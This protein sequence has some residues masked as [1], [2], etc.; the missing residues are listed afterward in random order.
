MREK[1][2][3]FISRHRWVPPVLT[4]AALVFLR[5]LTFEIDDMLL[6]LF[7][8]PYTIIWVLGGL[9]FLLSLLMG[10]AA[11][12]RLMNAAVVRMNEQCDPYA[13]LEE[14]NKQLLYVKSRTDR[15]MLAIN[16]A[17]ALVEMGQQTRAMEE[18]EAINTDDPVLTVQWRYV[19][20]HNL[21]LTALSCGQMEKAQVYYQKCL[22][23]FDSAK[24]KMRDK[25]QE[26]KTTLTAI[27]HLYHDEYEQAYAMLA[28]QN[29]ETLLTRVHRA[30]ALGRIALVQ[31]NIPVARV[32]LEFVA[33]NGGR[34]YLPAAANGLLADL[35]QAQAE[36]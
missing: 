7:G 8:G 36:Q 15:S 20:Y 22:Q 21:T 24:G 9:F 10:S 13:L 25:L 16:R 34:T 2:T 31:G 14:T 33:A 6:W 11:T 17:A 32:H 18:M 28:P 30:Y 3:R 27:M 1:Y 19:Y 29:P 26:H 12:L 5:L 23:Q 4:L 35:N